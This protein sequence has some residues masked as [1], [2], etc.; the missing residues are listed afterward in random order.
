MK[1]RWFAI[2][3]AATSIALFGAVGLVGLG[4]YYGVRYQRMRVKLEDTLRIQYQQEAM[5]KLKNRDGS[6]MMVHLANIPASDIA[7]EIVAIPRMR[8]ESER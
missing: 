8:H 2:L 4:A 1:D 6:K 3:V 7:Y 5:L